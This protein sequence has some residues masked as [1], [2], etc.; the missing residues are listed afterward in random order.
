MRRYLEGVVDFV[1]CTAAISLHI[2][3]CIHTHIL[4]DMS[5]SWMAERESFFSPVSWWK[6]ADNMIK[7]ESA[8]LQP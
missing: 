5:V 1:V 2:R 6:E 8:V 7:E 4:F 3:A